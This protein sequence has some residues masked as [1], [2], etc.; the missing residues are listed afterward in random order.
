MLILDFDGTL[1]D[2]EKEGAPFRAGYLGDIA[3]LTGTSIEDVEAMAQTF[4]A[5]VAADPDRYGWMF[6]G[7]I[8][9]PASVDP[10][11]RIMPVAR[12]IFDATGTFQSEADRTHLLDGILYKYNYTKTTMAFR[13]GAAQM[14]AALEGTAT[15][16]VTN[17]HTEPVKAKIATLD[18]QY[19]HCA[20]LAERVH[21]RAQKYILDMDYDALPEAMSV[22]NLDRPIYLRRRHYFEV[23]DAL[24]KEEGAAWSDVLVVGDI[25]ELDLSLPLHMGARVGLVVNPFTPKYERDF[26]ASHDRGTLIESLAEVPALLG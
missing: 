24:R 3:V 5:E 20:W 25:F 10:Y 8:V 6:H 17:S 11:L 23:L 1:T 2:A 26:L 15:H 21:G 18:A 22:P 12:K 16:V 19:G 7:R 9:A 14:V 13:E 4:E